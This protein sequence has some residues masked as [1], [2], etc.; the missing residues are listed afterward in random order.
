MHP[1][2]NESKE[3]SFVI[4]HERELLL[5]HCYSCEHDPFSEDRQHVSTAEKLNRRCAPVEDESLTV[6]EKVRCIR[7]HTKKVA[8]RWLFKTRKKC[9]AQ[10]SRKG[11]RCA[12]KKCLLL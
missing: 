6:L 12:R 7:Q 9:E 4:K 11:V 1:S 8:K 3:K 5:V 10:V 2:E